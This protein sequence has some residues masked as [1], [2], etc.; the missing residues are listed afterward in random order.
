MPGLAWLCRSLLAARLSRRCWAA[1]SFFDKTGAGEETAGAATAGGGA[2][3][4]GC[5][6]WV[7]GPGLAG[8]GSACPAFFAR[9]SSIELACAA[10]R[11]T[12][13]CWRAWRFVSRA[14]SAFRGRLWSAGWGE[15]AFST[16]PGGVGLTDGIGFTVGN[17][18]AAGRAGVGVA[19][20]GVTGGR[21]FA[22]GR[23]GRSGLARV[24]TGETTGAALAKGVETFVVGSW[25]GIAG[26]W[27]GLTNRFGGAFDGG[28]ASAWILA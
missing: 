17:G 5:A 1:C 24:S 15:E 11:S 10:R 19:T 26:C 25:G 3:G 20:G 6:G 9:R 28:V 23:A 21:G 4:A 27:S 16:G 2:V 12:C 8:D 14:A 13:A 22:P 7:A 18:F